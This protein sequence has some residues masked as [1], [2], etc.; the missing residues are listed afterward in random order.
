M[1]EDRERGGTETLGAEA[2]APAGVAAGTDSPDETGGASG[3]GGAARADSAAMVRRAWRPAARGLLVRGGA[4]LLVAAALL[5]AALWPRA[6]FTLDVGTPG[7][8]LF[9]AHVYG[10]ERV[11]E[12]TYR[13]TGQGGQDATLAV[14]GWA[15]VRRARL[16]VRAQALP[17]RA[18]VALDVRADG[19]TVGTLQVGGAMAAQSL[20]F[21]VPAGGD[22]AL[23]F[24]SA[25]AT[26][27]GDSRTLG[28]KLDALRLEP[29]AVDAGAYWRAV[30][31]GL[32]LLLVLVALGLALVAGVDGA[33]GWGLRG[34]VALAVPLA[35]ALTPPWA[36]ALAPVADGVAAAGLALRHRRR[37]VGGLAALWA[38]LDRSRVADRVALGGVVLYLAVLLPYV[39]AAPW[40]N[41]ADYADNAVVA[42]N[43]VEGHG[44]SVDYVAQFYRDYPTLRHPADTWPPLQP[45]LIAPF[46]AVFGPTTFA[47]KLPNVFIMAALLWLA[48]RAGMRLWSP[49]V[50]LL[51]LALLAVQGD[52][53]QGA[54]YPLNDVAFTFLAFASLLLL[55]RL[56]APPRHAPPRPPILGGAE[57][58]A[59]GLSRPALLGGAAGDAGRPPPPPNPGGSHEVGPGNL[60]RPTVP[61]GATALASGSPPQA[62]GAGGGVAGGRRFLPWALLGLLGGLLYLSKPSGLT[63]LAG[64]GTWALWHGWRRGRLRPVLAGG[65]V[66]AVVAGVTALP[67]L[68]RNFVTFGTPFYSTEQYDAW[69]LKYQPWE[70][71][72]R[73]Y[74]GRL[75]LPHPRLLVGYGF[76]AV[77]GAIGQQFRLFWKDV[78]Q[79]QLVPLLFLPLIVLGVLVVAGRRR[80][81]LLW[82]L[83]AATVPYAL[84]VL[85]Y[86]HYEQRYALYLLPWAMLLGAAGFWWLHDRLAAARG[87]PLAGVLA[88][89]V[90]ALLFQPQIAARVGDAA[91]DLGTPSSVTIAAWVRANTPPGAVV[92]TRNPWELAFHSGHETVML[93]YDDRATIEQVARRYHATYLQLD[94]LTDRATIR[95]ALAPLYQGQEAFGFRMVYEL[96]DPAGNPIALIYRFPDTPGGGP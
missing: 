71:I 54:V 59:G 94:H 28:V 73:V 70:Q 63:L 36:L 53:F 18:P 42:R 80:Q 4:P 88:L 5:L 91:G 83:A 26:V 64:A 68:V 82:A 45:L 50:G 78:G 12:Y 19:R 86:W 15:A 74:A 24:H 16:T 87:A 3:A 48:Y 6:A 33:A 22:F 34:G 61:G 2:D 51:A 92:M 7:D 20:T 55:W 84:L 69:I 89:V 17:E 27:P 29:L 90:L 32:G 38:A 8:G 79:G 46:F 52:L 13:W 37:L 58:E 1:I 35:A 23:S 67:W 93:P 76:D 95:P 57:D 96:R 49:R 65:A 11:A 30:W 39:W 60:S 44:F 72:Y 40:I 66:A 85:V 56:V 77:T 43:L 62:W 41:H 31:P 9:L 81:A 25:L 75:P 14:P 21:D 10:D 47:A